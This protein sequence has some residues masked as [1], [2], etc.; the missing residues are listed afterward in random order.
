M[1]DIE[2]ILRTQPI[3][4]H[5]QGPF[6]LRNG[7]TGH[8]ARGINDVDDFSGQRLLVFALCIGW[9]H[10]HEMIQVILFCFG[11]Q[12][13]TRCMTHFRRPYQFKIMIPGYWAVG[14]CNGFLTLTMVRIGDGVITAFEF[15]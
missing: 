14:K 1:Y 2:A 7:N 10:H 15:F 6:G 13:R 3:Q 5:Q 9:Q 11:E 8:G 12:G 4:C